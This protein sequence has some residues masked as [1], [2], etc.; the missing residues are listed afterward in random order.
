MCCAFGLAAQQISYEAWLDSVERENFIA[1]EI[2]LDE[3]LFHQKGS[4]ITPGANGSQASPTDQFLHGLSGMHM[5][6][7][8]S[9]ANEPVLRG[10]NSDRYIISVDG[11]RIFGAC[12]DKMDPVSSY[13]ETNNLRSMDVGFGAEDSNQGISTGGNVNF[14]LKKPVFNADQPV[15]ASLGGRFSS[16]SGGFDQLADINY[17]QGKLAFRA[18]GVHRKAGNYT[19]GNRQEVRFSQYEKVNYAVSLAYRIG[20][21]QMLMVDFLGDHAWDVGYPALPMDVAYAKANVVGLTYILPEFGKLTNSEVKVYHNFID[22][23]MD[24]TRRDSVAMHMDM[25]GQTRTSGAYLSAQIAAGKGSIRMKSDVFTNFSHAEMT[26]YANEPGGAPMYMLTWPDVQR[27]VGGTGLEYTQE[28]KNGS[29]R[30]G[31]RGEYSG[32]KIKSDAGERQLSVFGKTGLQNRARWL[33]SFHASY[34]RK[35][36]ESSI[37]IFKAAYGERLPSVSEQFG[38]YLFNRMDGYDYLGD[39]D[40]KKEKNL[41]LE[42]AYRTDNGAIRWKGAAFFY[43]FNDYIMGR[44]HPEWQAMTPGARGIKMYENTPTALMTG[45]EMDFDMDLTQNAVLFVAAKYVFGQDYSGMPLPQMPPLKLNVALD[46]SIAGIQV[47]P[48]WEGATAQRRISSR[49]NEP[50]TPSYQVVNIR[51]SRTFRKDPLRYTFSTGV[52][53][54]TQTVYREHIDISDI[55]RPG[56]N[57]YLTVNIKW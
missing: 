14:K 52:E 6:R 56:R 13:I 25:P 10:L 21:D 44:Y 36:S 50:V 7:R 17:S 20:K 33:G 29:V 57:F 15:M 27:Q 22:H 43:Y 28:G 39:P 23:A 42:A 26:M 16:V 4:G 55:L 37:L 5:M 53:N 30:V 24:D 54:V 51:L 41:H 48:E 47:L 32:T 45:G 1:R 40:L 46:M 49:F 34:D 2:L 35:A 8:G 18:S 38:Y 31:M 9:F 12:T 3:L 11:M 19:D